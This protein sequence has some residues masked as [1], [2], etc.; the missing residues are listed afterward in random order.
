MDE[1]LSFHAQRSGPD[2]VPIS[3]AEYTVL[4]SS[5]DHHLGTDSSPEQHRKVTTKLP[6]WPKLQSEW[7]RIFSRS[8]EGGISP[9]EL[10][11]VSRHIEEDRQ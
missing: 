3:I 7:R 5:H 2:G 10:T 4:S 1:T 9:E 11:G 6:Q 8:V